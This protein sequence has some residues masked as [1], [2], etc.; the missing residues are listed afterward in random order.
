MSPELLEVNNNNYS[1]VSGDSVFDIATSYW[2]Y[3]RGVGVQVPVG[4]RI[5]TSPCRPYQL[6]GP[7][8]LLSSGYQGLFTGGK[9][10]GA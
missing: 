5:F 2:L 4:S 1:L 10:A 8:N 6:W 7:P 3:D 9:A